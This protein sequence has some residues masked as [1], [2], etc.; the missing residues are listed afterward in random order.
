MAY[1]H[2]LYSV[3]Q[4]KGLP[5]VLLHGLAASH[6]DWDWLAPLL[7]Q[8]E[9][10][11]YLP[12]LLGHG[13]SPRP[14]EISCYTLDKL[15][16]ALL[17]WMEQVRVPKRFFLIG[18][19]LGGYLSLKIAINHPEQV[20]GLVLT[21]PFFTLKQILPLARQALQYPT[22]S[23][24][25]LKLAT[26]PMVNSILRLASPVLGNYPPQA[27]WRTATDYTRTIPA[28]MR[29]PA[30]AQDLTPALVSIKA[31]AI[32]IWGKNDLMLQPRYFERLVQALPNAQ[33]HA[34]PACGHEPHLTRMAQFNQLTL[35][36]L[37]AHS[38]DCKADTA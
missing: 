14:S 26:P 25:A 3:I 18:H 34:F 1:H 10:Q 6:H 8:F 32:V 11:V 15:Y 23:E 28:S 19:S 37:K 9:Y 17:M 31:P 21:A 20:L 13:D 5:V 2:S 29:F 35:D 16:T 22:L 30:S 7:V 27:R 4:G 12:D 33:G 36:F 24:Q 38:F